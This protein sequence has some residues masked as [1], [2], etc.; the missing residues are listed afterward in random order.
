VFSSIKEPTKLPY[1]PVV[2]VI[3]WVP[4]KELR[5]G[6]TIARLYHYNLIF[7]D[8]KNFERYAIFSTLNFL[9]RFQDYIGGGLGHEVAHIIQVKGKIEVE[10]LQIFQYIKDP[11]QAEGK[12][13]VDAKEFYELF[14]E[15]VQ[16]TIRKWNELSKYQEIMDE[17]AYDAEIVNMKRFCELIFG[18][19]EQQFEHHMTQMI[20][21]GLRKNGLRK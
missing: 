4:M 14:N 5:S 7:V 16:S 17:V 12:K 20:A 1:I 15:P 6:S 19:K 9:D 21:E 2:Y 8:P 18:D 3:S 11:I 13:E 10:L